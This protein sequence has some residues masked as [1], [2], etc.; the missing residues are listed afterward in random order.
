MAGVVQSGT[1]KEDVSIIAAMPVNISAVID[2][3]S[4]IQMAVP[5]AVQGDETAR[6]LVHSS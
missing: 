1:V 3:M 2:L 6:K 5:P 4:G